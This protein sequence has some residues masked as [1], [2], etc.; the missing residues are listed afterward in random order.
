[1][2]EERYRDAEAVANIAEAMSPKTPGLRT[3]ELTARMVGYTADIMAVVDARHKG[4]IDSLFQTELSHIPTPDEPPILYPDPETWQ[5]LTERRKKYKAV[6]LTQSNPN[7]AKIIAALDDKTELE[8]VDQ[9][10]TDVVEYL[11]ERHEIEIQLDSRALSDEGVGSDTPVTRNIK[12]ISL[13]S[14][15]RLMLGELDLTYV[16]RNE[17]LMITTKTEAENMLTNKVYPVADLV[18]PVRPPMMGGRMGGGMMG[19]GGM[20]MGF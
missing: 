14:A 3:A 7:E 2:D 16:I 13:R 10:L 15:L 1:M 17:V 20:G 4:V 8:F 5:L 19:R 9:P 18:I 6:D 11:K 12:G